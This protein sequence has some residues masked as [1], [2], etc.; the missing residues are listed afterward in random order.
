[1]FDDEQFPTNDALYWNDAGESNSDMAGLP[2]VSWERVSDF[3]DYTFWGNGISPTDI[4]QGY[5]GNCW[6]MAA[7]SA[8]AEREGRIDEIFVNDDISANGIYALQMY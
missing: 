1:M 5:I 6:V 2:S 3:H 7:V 4:N 8:L